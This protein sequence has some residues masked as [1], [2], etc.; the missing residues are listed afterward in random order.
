MTNAEIIEDFR[1]TEMFSFIEYLNTYFYE[2]DNE[3]SNN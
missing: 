2:D 3:E 1:N